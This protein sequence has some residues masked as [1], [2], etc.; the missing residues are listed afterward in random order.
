[1]ASF[2]G[3]QPFPVIFGFLA[4]FVAALAIAISIHEAAHAWTANKLGDPTARLQGRISLNP[5]DHIDLIG[6]II[7]PMFLF[8]F[9]GFFFGWAKPTPINPWNFA[10][11]RRDTALVSI[12]GPLSNFALAFVFGILFR[13]LA[14]NEVAATVL[15][16]LVQLNIT[17][18]IFNLIPVPPLDGFKVVAG[19][20]PKNLAHQW[21]SLERYGFV[22]LLFFFFF[23]YQLIG[24][25]LSALMRLFLGILTGTSL[26]I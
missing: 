10:H 11:P 19:L 1:M 14:F 22:I 8:L 15:F 20:L 23:G 26:T 17:L 13:F 7:L 16:F 12:A 5:V 4:V 21:E 18:A 3:G 6:T 25:F 9:A 2:L 24:P